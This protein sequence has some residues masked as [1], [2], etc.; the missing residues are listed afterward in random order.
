MKRRSPKSNISHLFGVQM[1]TSESKPTV[2][3]DQCPVNRF[4]NYKCN[5]SHCVHH[6][7]FINLQCVFAHII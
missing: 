3:Q 5:R 4:S 2:P 7:Y 1:V 6:Q